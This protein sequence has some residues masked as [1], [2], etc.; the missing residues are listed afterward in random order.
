MNKKQFGN[1]FI[2]LTGQKFGRLTV[3]KFS[4]K[5][6]SE[7][8]KY[9]LC[10]CDCGNEKI[11]YEN[12]FRKGKIKSCGCLAK[13]NSIIQ[14]GK[15]K[16][17]KWNNKSCIKLSKSGKGQ[18]L[19]ELSS[20]WKGGVTS[21]NKRM[22]NSSFFRY[23]REAVFERDNFV[24]Q[25]CGRKGG[26]LHPHHI[27]SFSKYIRKRFELSNGITLCEN[28][29]KKF[30]SIYGRHKFTKQNLYSFLQ[31]QQVRNTRYNRMITYKEKTLCL[32]EWAERLNIKYK[33]LWQRI[34]RGWNIEE[35]FN[36]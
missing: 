6:K 11:I 7:K 35:A 17:S 27:L 15:R 9:F 1:G 31:K 23:W 36:S 8:H 21:Y 19:R 32:A 5:D 16:N 33:I 18:Y 14:G 4:H 25:K 10:K 26:N 30:H 20:Q 13:E 22:R 12:H 34:Q 29:H 28:C 24:C 2:N 3:V